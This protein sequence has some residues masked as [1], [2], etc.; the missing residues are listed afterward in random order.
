M[1]STIFK[2]RQ[3][4]NDK[5]VFLFLGG[6]F[7]GALL[8]LLNSLKLGQIN[9]LNALGFLAIAALCGYLL[10]WLRQMRFKVSVNEKRIKYKLFP[11]HK[12]AQRI[13]WDEVESCQIVKTSAAAQWHGGNVRFSG[14]SWFSLNGRNGLSIE[15][16]DGRR[17]FIG[18]KDIDSL[19]GT[20]DNFSI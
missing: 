10:W 19:V 17:I 2:E 5:I 1:E 8:G 15:T 13:T 9:L 14:E 20:L 16:K 6:G 7:I 4:F 18:C 12:K 3:C 11:I